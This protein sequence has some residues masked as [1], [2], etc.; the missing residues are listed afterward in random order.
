MIWK[1]HILNPT[2][3]KL[4]LYFMPLH[5]N[6]SSGGHWT[7]TGPPLSLFSSNSWVPWLPG[8]LLT[9]QVVFL[10]SSSPTSSYQEV[11]LALVST[12]GWKSL[13][14]RHIR[15]SAL[16]LTGSPSLVFS[17]SL[18]SSPSAS[19]P[20]HGWWS[21]SFSHWSTGEATITQPHFQKACGL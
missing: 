14:H 7:R 11:S 6:R 19:D 16:P 1:F 5:C 12:T 13:Y 4:M 3:A 10:C 8:S 9:R 2:E 21:A 17:S 18:S 20:F 15:A